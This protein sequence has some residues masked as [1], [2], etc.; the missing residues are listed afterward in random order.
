MTNISQSAIDAL[1]KMNFSTP[2]G[3]GDRYRCVSSLDSDEAAKHILTEIC[4]NPHKYLPDELFGPTLKD[5]LEMVSKIKKANTER[6]EA[7]AELVQQEE[8]FNEA[9]FQWVAALHEEVTAKLDAEKRATIAELQEDSL[10]HAVAHLQ[11]QLNV[12]IQEKEATVKLLNS[13]KNEE[14][15]SKR[16]E[17]AIEL[18]KKDLVQA[19]DQRDIARKT[20]VDI[21]KDFAKL[22]R[23]YQCMLNQRNDIIKL[24][25][26]DTALLIKERDEQ[27]RLADKMRIELAHLR[28]LQ[29]QWSDNLDRKCKLA[30][31]EREEA[32]IEGM[33][34]LMDEHS[35]SIHAFGRSK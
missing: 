34:K 11:E 16:Y 15:W 17:T 13:P 29:S 6:D 35:E 27:K 2:Y 32:L 31:F 20:Q 24:S 30:A 14:E 10:R 9:S 25:D 18:L 22:R 8:E 28:T 4:K 19:L 5:T 23:D 3:F 12:A 21:E 33:Q 26:S 7:K 1:R